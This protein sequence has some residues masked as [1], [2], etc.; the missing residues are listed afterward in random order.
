MLAPKMTFLLLIFQRTIASERRVSLLAARARR[1][2]SGVVNSESVLPP[3]T[4]ADERLGLEALKQ[5]VPL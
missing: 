4:G 2:F 1:E 5:Q 3:T